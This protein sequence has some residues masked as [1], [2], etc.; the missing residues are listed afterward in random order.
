MNVRLCV[1][2]VTIACFLFTSRASLAETPE[3][4]RID[5]VPTNQPEGMPPDRDIFV[6]IWTE[7]VG[8][9]GTLPATVRH[10]KSDYVWAAIPISARGLE[11]TDHPKDAT[12]R[13]VSIRPDRVAASSGPRVWLEVR[14]RLNR[15]TS[16]GQPFLEVIDTATLFQ[17]RGWGR[18]VRRTAEGGEW[19]FRLPD[20][21]QPPPGRSNPISA[22]VL[23][24]PDA[25][26]KL[27]LHLVSA[28]P[29]TP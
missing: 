2:I 11:A 7:P 5:P 6:P 28:A 13:L 20:P 4:A 15:A 23:A 10:Q 27:E 12:A 25:T 21:V 18:L 17:S 3:R 19:L 9:G 16:A 29:A 22:R 8:P 26:R 24:A 1:M 14:I